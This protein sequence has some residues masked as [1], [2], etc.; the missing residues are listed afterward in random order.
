MEDTGMLQSILAVAVLLP[1]RRLTRDTGVGRPE[2]IGPGRS[3]REHDAA[4]RMANRALCG[5]DLPFIL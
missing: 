1:V 2:A 4:T 5:I 3:P